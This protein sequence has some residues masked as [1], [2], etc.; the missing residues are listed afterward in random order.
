MKKIKSRLLILR[1]KLTQRYMRQ[2]I[3]GQNISVLRR[4]KIRLGN[5]LKLLPQ[6]L[7]NRDQRDI[8]SRHRAVLPPSGFQRNGI[9][10]QG[11]QMLQ[12]AAQHGAQAGKARIAASDIAFGFDEI[13]HGGRGAA[14]AGAMRWR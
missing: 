5:K 4:A 11:G 2:G 3:G 7:I 9:P 13:K 8:E 1:T 14:L 6:V 12:T 10:A